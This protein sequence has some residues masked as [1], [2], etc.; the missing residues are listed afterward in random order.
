MIDLMPIK[1]AILESRVHSVPISIDMSALSKAIDELEVL[2]ELAEEVECR[3]V[4]NADY[5]GDLD[6]SRVENIL[7]ALKGK[8]WTQ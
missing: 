6:L 8:Y 2:R 4:A 5:L 7:S 1:M 3:V